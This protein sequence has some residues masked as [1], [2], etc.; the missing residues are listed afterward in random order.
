MQGLAHRQVTWRQAA[1]PSCRD[2][3]CRGAARRACWEISPSMLSAV[4][5]TTLLLH[6]RAGQHPPPPH[7]RPSPSASPLPISESPP[8]QRVPINPRPISLLVCSVGSWLFGHESWN[9][10]DSVRTR[11][12]SPFVPN[13]QNNAN[14]RTTCRCPEE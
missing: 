4:P 2:A 6:L 12:S 14:E 1:S 5:V 8:C 7:R 13:L 9:N 11:G 10:S 3:V